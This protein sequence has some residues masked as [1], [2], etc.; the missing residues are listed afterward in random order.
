MFIKEAVT[1]RMPV[2]PL[3]TKMNQSRSLD[4]LDDFNSPSESSSSDN[5]DNDNPS[6]ATVSV[7]PE[8]NG[9]QRRKTELFF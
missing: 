1:V 4:E 6:S 3:C 7:V 2:A 9:K 8:K 5:D